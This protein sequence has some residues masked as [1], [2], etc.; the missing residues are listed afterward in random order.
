[1]RTQSILLSGAAIGALIALSCGLPADAATKKHHMAAPA[2]SKTQ[3]EIDEL[4]AK[5]QFL[6]ERLDEQAA[7]SRDDQAQLKAAQDAVAQAKA[8]AAAAMAT[9]N[10][11]DARIET[12]PTQVSTAVAAVKPKTDKLYYKGVSITMGGFAAAESVYRSHDETADIGSSY[13]KLPFPN[14]PASRTGETHLTGRQ[15]RYSL[16]V[17]GDVNPTTQAAFYGEFDFLGAAQTANS[18]ES[19]SYQ[20]RI[21]NLYGAIDWND[22]GWHLLAGQSWSLVTMNSKGITP[23]NEVIPPTIEAQYV[24]GFVWARQPQVRLTK[25]FMDKQLWV[26][27]SAENP[28]TTYGN[29]KAATGVTL[30]SPGGLS[31]APTSQYYS[32]TNYSLNEYPDV[33]A[34]VAFEPRIQDHT[35]HLEAFAIGRN[36]YDRVTIVPS[37]GTQAATLG[38]VAGSSSPSN[39]GGGFGGGATFDVVPKLLDVEVSGMAGN[40]IGRYGSSQ[41]PDTTVRP[42]GSLVGM[43]ETMVMAGATLHPMPQLDVYVFGGQEQETSKTY[44]LG[45]TVFGTGAAAVASNAGCAVEGGTC[46]PYTKSIDQITAG[47]WDRFYSGPFGHLQ[48][49]IQYSYTERQ[50]FADAAGNGPK[51]NDNM[52]FTSFRYYPF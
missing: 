11:D 6:T 8:S 31:Q 19:N 3:A 26:A 37:T 50:A 24:P 13:A 16:L 44:T 36:F 29:T 47:F 4:E 52:I 28:Q 48:V 25:D 51:T 49:G 43:P 46:S 14:D 27:I 40:G 5:V 33:V 23:R 32:G 41:L 34:K 15:S 12:I 39:W 18:N 10:A 20:P 9:A 21:R 17:Q 22:T 1:M 35:L 30:A 42:D 38:L 45:S 7:V 2:A